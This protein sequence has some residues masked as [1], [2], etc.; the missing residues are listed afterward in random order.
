MDEYVFHPPRRTGFL[1][2]AGLIILLSAAGL[3]G[4]WQATSARVGPTLLIYMLPALVAVF[5]VPLLLYRTSAIFGANYVVERDGIRLRWGLRAED[6]PMDDV[7]WVGKAE[8]WKGRLP[9]PFFHIPGAVLG[10]RQVHDARTLE[11]MAA[12][13]NQLI[14]ITTPGHVYAIS[15]EDREAFLKA[16]RRVSELGSV[17][18]IPARSA[19]P[20]LLLSLSWSE[21]LPRTLIL[22]G[23]ALSLLLLMWA[24]LVIPGREQVSLRLDPSGRALGSVPAVQLLLLPV[25]NLFFYIID[26]ILGLFFYR[27]TESRPAAYLMWGSSIFTSLLFMGAVYFISQAA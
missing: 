16:F 10:V 19:Y 20:A 3:F 17:T 13:A 14:L 9:K 27:R 18:P 26:A 15:P 12:S 1:V 6:I 23:L 7:Q 8:E 5:L 21:R 2:H 4:M 24:A 25:L 11:Y 22:L